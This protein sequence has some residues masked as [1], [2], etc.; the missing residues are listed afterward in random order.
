[1]ITDKE[2]LIKE[3]HRVTKPDGLLSIL[4][5]HIKVE[6]VAQLAEKEGLFSLRNRDGKLLN[7]KKGL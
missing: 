1:L 4:A 6:D 7:F 5:E 3:L 2:A